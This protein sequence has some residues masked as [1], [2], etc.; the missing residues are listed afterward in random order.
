PYPLLKYLRIHCPS[1][2]PF[3]PLLSFRQA[4]QSA[5]VPLLTH[6]SL[7]NVS[8]DSILALRWGSFT[9]FADSDWH[10][11]IVWRRLKHL[12]LKLLPPR[13]ATT[14]RISESHA[15]AVERRRERQQEWRTGIKI[16]HDWL[17]SFASTGT[18][19]SGGL[20]SLK[21]EWLN[22]EGPNPLLLDLEVDQDTE[23]ACTTAPPISW[24]RLQKIWLRGVCVGTQDVQEIKKRATELRCLM[25]Q[26]EL[27]KDQE[28]VGWEK[29]EG[30]YKWWEVY[31]GKRSTSL[32][33][34]N[35]VLSV[36]EER[37]EVEAESS[38][39]REERGV[40]GGTSS[41]AMS[42]SSM[43]VTFMMRTP[44]HGK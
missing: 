39:G 18:G 41:K 9:A 29:E 31:L 23:R 37:P 10:S 35:A 13:L 5:K 30:R 22:D 44:L 12:D 3:Y 7:S 28:T 14:P 19:S 8:L 6:L 4:L 36:V 40:M 15:E 32:R 34:D 27:L 33:G 1:E 42:A 25:V 38:R 21:F 43:D 16:L 2:D 24:N 17:N 20:E 26:Q 11:S